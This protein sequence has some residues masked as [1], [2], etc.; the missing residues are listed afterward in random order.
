VD[1]RD[2]TTKSTAILDLDRDVDET[3]TI[4]IAER[5]HWVQFRGQREALV[6][7]GRA[8]SAVRPAWDSPER[9]G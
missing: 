5:V 6:E 7:T 4:K 3:I 8:Q 2:A 1:D 9:R